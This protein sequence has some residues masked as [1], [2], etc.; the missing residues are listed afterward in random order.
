MNDFIAPSSITIYVKKLC[1]LIGLVRSS[2]FKIP[3]I[4]LILPIHYFYNIFHTSDHAKEFKLSTFVQNQKSSWSIKYK[5]GLSVSVSVCY[6]NVTKLTHID[7]SAKWS[8]I[9][10]QFS[11]YVE[12][13]LLSWLTMFMC[14][15]RGSITN[16]HISAKL[17]RIFMEISTIKKEV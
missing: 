10:M 17:S 5:F 13:R 11:A 4:N 8:L 7:I 16:N 1:Q 15:N 14:P 2:N 9:F 6:I 3:T 12:I